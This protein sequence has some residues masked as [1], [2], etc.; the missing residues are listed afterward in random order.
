MRYF[1][2]NSYIDRKE[3]KL[4]ELVHDE[5][6]LYEL[7]HENTLKKSPLM[8]TAKKLDIEE[9]IKIAEERFETNAEIDSRISESY[10]YH[11]FEIEQ[12]KKSKFKIIKTKDY[13][14]FGQPKAKD[15]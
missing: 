1:L 15:I 11:I 10:H 5:K 8:S 7:K 13:K 6:C 3:R 14:F 9:I 12:G 4:I 2:L